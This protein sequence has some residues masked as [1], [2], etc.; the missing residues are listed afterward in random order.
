MIKR[1]SLYLGDVTLRA[2]VGSITLMLLMEAVQLGVVAAH[3]LR[4]RR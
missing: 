2:A 3:V 4:E 1:A